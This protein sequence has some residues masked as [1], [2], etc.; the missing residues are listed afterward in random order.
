MIY[1]KYMFNFDS[2]IESK[3][4]Q[5]S[6]PKTRMIRILMS[7]LQEVHREKN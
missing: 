4:A 6:I 3:E 5:E 1:L 2:A 7:E